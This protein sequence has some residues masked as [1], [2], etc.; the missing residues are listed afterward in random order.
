MTVPESAIMTRSFFLAMLLATTAVEPGFAQDATANCTGV[1]P[2]IAGVA[3]DVS[4]GSVSYGVSNGNFYGAFMMDASGV[5]D[6]GYM[7]NGAFNGTNGVN[8]WSDFLNNPAA[9]N[10]A[11]TK[12]ATKAWRYAQAKGFDAYVGQTMPDGA[13]ITQSGLLTAMQFVG[14]Y[15]IGQYLTGGMQCTSATSDTSN[16][17]AG[18]WI[19][20][21]NNIDISALTGSSDGLSGGATCTAAAQV[22]AQQAAQATQSAAVQSA[23]QQ[24][25]TAMTGTTNALVNAAVQQLTAQAIKLAASLAGTS[26]TCPPTASMLLATPCS[27]YPQSLQ[28]FCNQYK[29]KLMNQTQCQSAEKY[30]QDA[31]KGKRQTECSQQTTMK[32]TSSVSFTLGC[33][34][35]V[36]DQGSMGNSV[37][38]ANSY[39]SNAAN[40][41]AGSAAASPQS[42]QANAGAD[43]SSAGSSGSAGSPNISGIGSD[44]GNDPQCM[45]K[46]RARVPNL[47]VLGRVSIGWKL[48]KECAIPNGVAYGGTKVKI[49]QN[50]KDSVMPMD[51]SLALEWELFSDQIVGLGVQKVEQ[52]G[53][54]VCKE[55]RHTGKLSEH[56]FG[57]AID[58][59]GW[60]VGNKIYRADSYFTDPSTK[61]WMVGQM[62]PIACHMWRDVMG[63]IIYS[64]IDPGHRHYHFDVTAKGT[65]ECREAA[66]INTK[67]LNIK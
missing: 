6:A 46:L 2:F 23:S 1:A 33:S 65:T 43:A 12:Y 48:G 37:T 67:T 16:T 53:I 39:G 66:G 58:V 56:S 11:F 13:V 8:A 34:S 35:T 49:T 3:Q 51:C 25:A 9:Q 5:T 20:V 27:S 45:Q 47:R 62:L 54:H 26:K 59:G 21:G 36:K 41:G 42:F 32:G 30:A 18:S 22:A 17:C 44:T 15:G 29:P 52:W 57:M 64:N 55:I 61:A 7:A 19:E 10:D 28:S 60:Y 14:P 24:S 38:A 63:P 50:G 4:Q 31:T 40:G